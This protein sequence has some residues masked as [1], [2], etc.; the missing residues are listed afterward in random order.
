VSSVGDTVQ[1]EGLMCAINIIKNNADY[2]EQFR[3]KVAHHSS[4]KH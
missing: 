4:S 1:S 2:K 3:V